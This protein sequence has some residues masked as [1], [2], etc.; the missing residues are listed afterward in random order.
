MNSCTLS[1]VKNKEIKIV[2][3]CVGE[4]EGEIWRRG[5]A[6]DGL[7]TQITR[8]QMRKE[9][10]IDG[11]KSR[12]GCSRWMSRILL[13]KVNTKKRSLQGGDR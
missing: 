13:D 5:V 11:G 3:T 12:K 2:K 7:P 6:L 8:R 9:T 4:E 10:H 1:K